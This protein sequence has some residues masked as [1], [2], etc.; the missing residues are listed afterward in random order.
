V[1]WLIFALAACVIGIW[2]IMFGYPLLLA[3]IGRSRGSAK[4]SGS[5]PPQ[6]AIVIPTLNEERLILDRLANLDTL[7][8]PPDLISVWVVDGGSCD[9]TP[10]L[11]RRRMAN[12]ARI[13]LLEVPGCR[14]KLDQLRRVLVEVEEELVV[15]SDADAAVEPGCVRELIDALESDPGTGLVGAWIRPQTM[16]PEERL[17]WRLLSALWWLEGEAMSAATVSGVCYAVRR[18]AVPELEPPGSADDVHIALAVASTGYRTRLSR[19]A[20]AVERRVPQTTEELLVYRRRRG[21]LYLS[22]LANTPAAMLPRG[23]RFVR[24]IRLL[25]FV[26]VPRLALVAGL[27]VAAAFV[28]GHGR[29]ALAVCAV[30]AASLAIVA[31]GLFYGSGESIGSW[32]WITT[33]FRHSFLTWYA[34]LSLRSSSV[35]ER[36]GDVRPPA[37]ADGDPVP[38]SSVPPAASV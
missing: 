29:L 5:D 26:A 18:S 9:D 36:S 11:V 2:V 13:H 21:G 17:H 32:R 16:L 30:P 25:Q 14:S 15:V 31:A 28:T 3:A 35:A 4:P 38:R 34:L 33:V 37:V 12:D 10:D 7:D 23:W 1:S 27:L 24:R 20:V 19:T 8:Y 6:I 22:E